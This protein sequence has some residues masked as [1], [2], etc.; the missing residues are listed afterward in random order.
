MNLGQQI[1]YYRNRDQLSQEALAEKIYVSRQSISNWENE[2]SYPDIHNLL[3][4]SVLFGVSLDELVKGDVKIMQEELGKSNLLKWTNWMFALMVAVPVSVGPAMYFF[5]NYGLIISG[6][7]F[8]ISL[9]AAYKVERL[10]KKHDLKTYQQIL[11]FLA[12]KPVEKAKPKL[13]DHLVT[14]GLTIASAAFAFIVVYGSMMLFN[15]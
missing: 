13:R 14:A 2:R 8:V 7:L 10:K 6:V 5:G 3:M 9:A 4:L 12:G 1:K 15:L 11:D